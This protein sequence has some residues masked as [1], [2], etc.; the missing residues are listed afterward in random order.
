MSQNSTFKKGTNVKYVYRENGVKVIEE[1]LAK[2][3]DVLLPPVE[4][5]KE[6]ENLKHKIYVLIMKVKQ[7]EEK[8]DEKHV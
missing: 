6:I 8:I 1:R 7:L 3:E 5:Q 2:L 4:W